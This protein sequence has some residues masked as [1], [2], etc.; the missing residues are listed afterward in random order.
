M[1][2]L[3]A[4]D[5]SDVNIVA[6]TGTAGT[7]GTNNIAYPANEISAY[8]FC[9]LSSLKSITLPLST[10]SIGY[11]AFQG[12]LS[13]ANVTIP[14][15]VTSIADYA[16]DSCISLVNVEIPNSVTSIGYNAFSNC[17]GLINMTLPNSVTS[18]GGYAFQSCISL[19]SIS[20][21][22]SL[23]TI[24][25]YAFNSCSSLKSITIPLGVNSIGV[26]AI[27]NCNN[28]TAINVE[29][30]NQY[31]YSLDGVLFDKNQTTLIQFPNGKAINNYTTPSSVTTIGES[32]FYSCNALTNITL[33]SS[34][35]SIG[36]SAFS[37]C[38]G[39]TS[40]TIPNSVTS[41]GGYAFNS[42]INLTSINIPLG[43]TSIGSYAISECTKLT[44]IN[45]ESGNQNYSSIDGVLFDKNQTT[46]I[47]YPNSKSGSYI[48]P[49]SVTTIGDYPFHNC[50]GLT[51]VTIPSSVIT[52]GSQAFWYCSG[53]TSINIPSSITS[54]GSSAFSNCT[55]LTSIYMNSKPLAIIYNTFY[56]V[57]TGISNCI[58]YVPYGTKALYKA[59]SNWKSF[60][61][62]VESASGILSNADNLNMPVNAGSST[63]GVT[64][65][66]T[67][68]ASSD[69]SWLTVSPD[70]GNGNVTLTLTAQANQLTIP[71]IAIITLSAA[72]VPSQTIT[73]KQ[74]EVPKIITVNSGGLASALT[75]TELSTVRNLTIT[76]TIDA[77]ILKPCVTI[78]RYYLRLI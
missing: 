24:G 78:C 6:Y 23:T 77:T 74:D 3:T 67:W 51:S 10:I 71:R 11:Y 61:N 73:V 30:G 28:L 32:A 39:L 21:S 50:T 1:P 47:Q 34:V 45:V 59:A 18:I 58:L 55:G 41:I 15:S 66:V 68:I 5:L 40:I 72:G 35:T 36:G 62:I 63:V 2:N 17:N 48:I 25:I 12:C 64:S 60:A 13:L 57:R 8:A 43:V 26:C 38:S 52:I 9:N 70:S 33:S 76:G 53:L 49:S 20:L 16:F 7:Y 27:L 75:S 42:C 56:G 31:F 54:I 69:Q 37:S 65:N 46:L 4:V 29:S 22:S 19:T 14:N 44:A